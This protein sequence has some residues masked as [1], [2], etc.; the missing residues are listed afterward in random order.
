MAATPD[1]LA[2][3]D[4]LVGIWRTSGAVLDEAGN[5]VM[6]ISG[7]DEYEWMPGNA[8]LIHRVD[9]MIGSD[10]TRAW[11]FVGDYDQE[12]GCLI[13]RA[14]DS[15]GAF[16]TMT[17]ELFPDGAWRL[18]GEGIRSTLWPAADRSGMTAKWERALDDGTWIAWMDMSF[19]PGAHSSGFRS[20]PDP[21]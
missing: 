7:T 8:W 17:V 21:K 1:L 11:E 5:P 18:T 19:E 3:L 20:R 9:V 12:R 15:S 2:A 13:A 4:P 6:G 14:F 16:D 10:R